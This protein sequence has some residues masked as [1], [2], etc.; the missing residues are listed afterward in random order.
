MVFTPNI[1]LHFTSLLQV[2]LRDFV[3]RL[4]SVDASIGTPILNCRPLFPQQ[5]T[6]AVILDLYSYAYPP[7][8]HPDRKGVRR[9]L[10][11][12]GVGSAKAPL[13]FPDNGR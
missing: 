8:G 13:L 5:I 10:R 4:S 1:N 7:F 11:L 12:D 3:T 2:Q 9:I 6:E